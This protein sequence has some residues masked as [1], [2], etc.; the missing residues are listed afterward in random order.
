MWRKPFFDSHSI[1]LKFFSILIDQ[2]HSFRILLNRIHTD[3]LTCTCNFNRNGTC[4]GADI[5]HNC[6]LG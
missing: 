6:I 3:L 2:F 4:S 1:C 5:I